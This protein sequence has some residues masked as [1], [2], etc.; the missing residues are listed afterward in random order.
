MSAELDRREKV[1]EA[2]GRMVWWIEETRL[3]QPDASTE[4]LRPEAITEIEGLVEEYVSLASA[5]LSPTREV[6]PVKTRII[7]DLAEI[8]SVGPML[9]PTG[10]LALTWQMV[11]RCTEL[12]EVLQREFEQEDIF[13]IW[14]GAAQA[15]RPNTRYPAAVGECLL[16][17]YLLAIYDALWPL[18]FAEVPSPFDPLLAI[19]EL[20][21]WPMIRSDQEVVV[22]VPRGEIQPLPASEWYEAIL[23]NPL[24][25]SGLTAFT[26]PFRRSMACARV[27][28]RR[29]VRG[30]MTE[31][32]PLPLSIAG[33]VS[34]GRD[35]TSDIVLPVGNVTTRHAKLNESDGSWWVTDLNST[36]GTLVGSATSQSIITET[37]RVSGQVISI[38]D[39]LIEVDEM[40]MVIG[41]LEILLKQ[42]PGVGADPRTSALVA[43]RPKF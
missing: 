28:H 2:L 43:K 41:Q 15:Q 5:A 29:R 27:T 24:V 22:Y 8:A 3:L 38:G 37:T 31:S 30:E 39:T 40:R 4:N 10:S 34:I 1:E 6:L 20:G 13:K 11:D 36:N 33:E 14:V 35:P 32:E 17:G 12:R 25:A 19:W 18:A 23:W 16:P 21:G 42:Q 9:E 7:S 26:S